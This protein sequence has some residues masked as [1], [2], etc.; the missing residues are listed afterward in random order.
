M[1][2]ER[3]AGRAEVLR[4]QWQRMCLRRASVRTINR[5]LFETVI[6]AAF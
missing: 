5:H 2:E 1:I 3:P 6:R 4:I